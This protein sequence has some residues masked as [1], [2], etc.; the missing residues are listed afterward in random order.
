VNR[1]DQPDPGS[2][3]SPYDLVCTA[4]AL[5]LGLAIGWIDLRTTE[6][7]VTIVPLLGA[8]LLL[9]LLQPASAWRWAVLEVLGLPIMEEVATLT[10]MPTAEPVQ[11][12]IRIVIVAF[13][14]ALSGAYV[15]AFLRR[16]R[17]GTSGNTG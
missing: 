6:V 14:F 2:R 12:D 8:G 15:G 7:I 13:V 16:M 4:L 9:G 5:I 10:G 3:H 11:F 1:R 17:R